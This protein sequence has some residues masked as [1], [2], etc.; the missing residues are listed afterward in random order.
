MRILVLFFR[1]KAMSGI[2]LL[3]ARAW[4]GGSA[5]AAR[6]EAKAQA[7]V[8]TL[9]RIRETARIRIGYGDTA[10]FSY[11]LPDGQ[12]V[13][14]SIE[15]CNKL[16]ESLRQKL[17]LERLDIEYV[18]RTPR[19]RVQLLNDGLY[20]IRFGRASCRERVCKYV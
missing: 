16:S 15:I 5:G 6:A 20:D 4:A 18:F 10:P 2:A 14:Y 13:G 19:N 3:L 12:V 17:G 1:I 11:R 7:P 9:E 8:P